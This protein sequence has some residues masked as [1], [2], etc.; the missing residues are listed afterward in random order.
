MQKRMIRDRASAQAAQ[1]NWLDVVT[2]ADVE[3]TS[4]DAAHP[5]EAALVQGSG[6]GWRAA[7]PGPQTV[8][9]LFHAP[10]RLRR[11]RLRFEEAG[12]ERTQEFTLRWS[13]DRGRTYRDIVRQQYTFAP[14]GATCEVE[15]LTVDLVAATA[16]DLTIIPDQRGG[17]Y[18]SLAEWRIG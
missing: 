18:A 2:L 4:E 10:Q 16:L 9:L 14:A 3:L 8:R 17:A 7:D 15:D 12:T 13:P 6:A 1:E 5:I 11:I